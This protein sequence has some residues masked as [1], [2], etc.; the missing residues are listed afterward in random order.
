[1]WAG[2]GGFF[3]GEGELGER[4]PQTLGLDSKKGLEDDWKVRKVSTLSYL[5]CTMC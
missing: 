5:H 3:N 1:M 4:N 2:H